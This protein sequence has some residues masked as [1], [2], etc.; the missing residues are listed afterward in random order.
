MPCARRSA[1]PNEPI[2]GATT[3]ARAYQ[4]QKPP[5]G[6]FSRKSTARTAIASSSAVAS[7]PARLSSR[8]AMLVRIWKT[9]SQISSP[10]RN[11]S[12]HSTSATSDSSGSHIRSSRPAPSGVVTRGAARSRGVGKPRVIS[13]RSSTV[14]SPCRAPSAAGGGQDGE[15]H[16]ACHGPFQILD[17]RLDV[18]LLAAEVALHEGLV[19]AL[20]DDPLD[21]HR[22]G[23]VELWQVGLAGFGGHALAR[24]VVEQLPRE[25]PHEPGHGRVPVGGGRTVQR[26][27]HR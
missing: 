19:L 23:L 25:Q 5:K 6:I 18:D 12:P 7:A 27:V 3:Q 13:S 10:G 22:A 24:G 15:E 21:Q 9:R 11:S 16:P 26:E 1:W 4:A 8:R 20:R 2:T 14:P 17:E